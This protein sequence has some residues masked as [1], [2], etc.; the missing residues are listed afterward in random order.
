MSESLEERIHYLEEKIKRLEKAIPT[1]MTCPVCGLLLTIHEE[2]EDIVYEGTSHAQC[3]H[4][5]TA[6]KVK[7]SK[8][9]GQE[10]TWPTRKRKISF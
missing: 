4:C 10:W 5:L 2:Y 3:Y 7:E 6:R 1:T 9:L 8:D